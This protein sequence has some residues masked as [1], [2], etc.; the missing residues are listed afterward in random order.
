MNVSATHSFAA[1]APAPYRLVSVVKSAR[2]V[3]AGR[4]P[5]VGTCAHCGSHLTNVATFRGTDGTEFTVGLDCAKLA[6][7]SIAQHEAMAK[8]EVALAGALDAFRPHARAVF[9][10]VYMDVRTK[11]AA[12]PIM[13]SFVK[14]GF[15]VGVKRAG[16]ARYFFTP[17]GVELLSPARPDLKVINPETMR[18]Y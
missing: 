3:K 4:E 9:V 5:V 2:E 14:L 18:P 17:A 1:L 12:A 8:T 7:E 16:G 11:D 10:G 15:V 6:G 13:K